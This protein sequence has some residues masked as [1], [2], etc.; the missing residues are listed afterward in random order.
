MDAITHAISFARFFFSFLGPRARF[1]RFRPRITDQIPSFVFAH[2]PDLGAG[3]FDAQFHCTQVNHRFMCVKQRWISD[4][5]SFCHR[6]IA[7]G[8]GGKMNRNL[9]A[10][11]VL[12]M[13]R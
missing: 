5:L 1:F 2:S 8:K 11:P 3:A 10:I 13:V 7:T 12:F 4:R 6:F 9:N